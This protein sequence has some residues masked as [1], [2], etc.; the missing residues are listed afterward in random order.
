MS[1]AALPFV[2][3]AY[4]D[5]LHHQERQ[6]ACPPRLSISTSL[7]LGWVVIFAGSKGK[8]IVVH[9]SG[10]ELA[11]MSY[12]ALPIVR[13][14]IFVDWS[15]RLTSLD[16]LSVRYHRPLHVGI[17]GFQFVSHGG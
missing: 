8:Y 14:A 10:N 9:D 2:R 1:Y 3:S 11:C 16:R 17:E 5:H 4:Q 13:S 7:S 15:E 12:A 6:A